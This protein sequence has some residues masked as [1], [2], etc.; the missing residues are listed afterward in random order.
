MGIAAIF[1][2][3]ALRASYPL[4]V[5]LVIFF[6]ILTFTLGLALTLFQQQAASRL[7]L[8]SNKASIER[9]AREIEVHLNARAQPIRMAV[10][11]LAHQRSLQ[12]AR[13]LEARLVDLPFLRETLDQI[14]MLSS[15]YIA[16]ENGD[17]FI[18]S[19][20]Q[21]E[22][23]RDAPED[24]AYLAGSITHERGQRLHE[25][26]YF[27]RALRLLDRR[28]AQ[29]YT[30]FDPRE[31]GWYQ[32][33]RNQPG[34]LLSSP[35]YLFQASQRRGAS[36]VREASD[37]AAV[38]GA[39][40]GVRELGQLLAGHKLTTSS[41][42][43]LL[44]DDR[45]A[46]AG[47]HDAAAL[48]TAL[49]TAGS[50]NR[51]QVGQR[52]WHTDR[53]RL[54][55]FDEQRAEL[56]F[57]VPEDELLAGVQNVRRQS[58]LLAILIV[59]SF[60]PLVWWQ[61]HRLCRPLE[62]I[63][64]ESAEISHFRFADAPRQ[65][66]LITEINELAQATQN[67]KN[68]IRR[69]LDIGLALASERDFNA[70]LASILRESSGI[71]RARGGILYLREAEAGWL[72]PA[73]ALWDGERVKDIDRI[74][75][76][77]EELRHYH[78]VLRALHQGTLS[79]RLEPI[80]FMTWFG[81]LGVSEEHISALAIALK[82]RQE[83]TVGVLLLFEHENAGEHASA[84]MALME[85]IS[86]SAALAIESHRLIQEQQNLLEAFIQLIASAN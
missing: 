26:L 64:R 3:K 65:T 28:P 45:I 42:I 68:T 27:D 62:R 40:L 82:N 75:A 43:W 70:L 80:E 84:M 51:V 33:A 2:L 48:K 66:S 71:M 79:H 1:P 83:Q 72:T 22:L 13:S 50:S 37:N 39:D 86:G 59:V 16:Y 54:H 57:A 10:H 47:D 34:Q 20:M 58:L 41:R 30:H 31:R 76:I 49:L 5:H 44:D 63:T 18:L 15:L 7:L 35:F 73:Q 12:K 8:S 78:P 52:I 21:E 46:I 38:V 17:F 85:A 61:A 19:A 81:A 9:S 77:C 56:L 36:F 53:H 4:R 11:A 74:P 69:F 67:A 29:A 23:L 60:L 55:L 24:A 14:P 6:S 25:F 32:L